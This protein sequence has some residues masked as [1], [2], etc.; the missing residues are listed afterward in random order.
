M[1]THIRFSNIDELQN[2]I[3]ARSIVVLGVI[4]ILIEILMNFA[5]NFDEEEDSTNIWAVLLRLVFIA[6]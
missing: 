2:E 1:H 3:Y 6:R 4:I 5:T